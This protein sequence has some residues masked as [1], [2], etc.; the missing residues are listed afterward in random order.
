MNIIVVVIHSLLIHIYIYMYIYMYIYIFIY[1]WFFHNTYTQHISTSNPKMDGQ[2]LKERNDA[3][4][5]QGQ[6]RRSDKI[7]QWGFT[8]DAQEL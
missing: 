5:P 3:G 7:N 6:S 4:P 2:T 1:R 8:P